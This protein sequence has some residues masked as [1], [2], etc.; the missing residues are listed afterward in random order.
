[1]LSFYKGDG[2]MLKKSLKIVIFIL[3]LIIFICNIINLL[4]VLKKYK[5][6]NSSVETE[7]KENIINVEISKNCKSSYRKYSRDN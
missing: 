5:I 6:I 7:F 1:M 4:K 3:I 2:F